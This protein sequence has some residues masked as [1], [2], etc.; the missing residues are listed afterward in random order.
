MVPR[1]GPSN[2][3]FPAPS[4]ANS[5]RPSS[6]VIIHTASRRFFVLTSVTRVSRSGV[7]VVE[8]TT[9]PATL[10]PAAAAGFVPPG[11]PCAPKENE[12]HSMPQTTATIANRQFRI[13]VHIFTRFHCL[14]P[15]ANLLLDP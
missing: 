14:H 5:N 9:T 4:P 15:D 6:R 7:P 11:S 8:L 2:E 12:A 1:L 13:P 10:N 3:F